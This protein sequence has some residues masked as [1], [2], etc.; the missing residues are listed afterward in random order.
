MEAE[1]QK[2]AHAKREDDPSK[3]EHRD[4]DDGGR[5]DSACLNDESTERVPGGGIE[6]RVVDGGDGLVGGSEIGA[7]PDRGEATGVG[8]R[9]NGVE[10]LR[11]IIGL[12][13]LVRLVKARYKEIV[14][15]GN[16]EHDEHE[17]HPWIGLGSGERMDAPLGGEECHQGNE[18]KGGN[19]GERVRRDSN[20][21]IELAEDADERDADQ[22][23]AAQRRLPS[24]SDGAKRKVSRNKEDERKDE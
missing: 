4:V 5:G 17:G 15:Q 3:Y 18:D 22:R 20:E 9:T 21:R 24:H 23:A 2:R 6:R 1:P 13:E 16:A 12:E 10:M 8:H 14:G 7:P 11:E 19:Q